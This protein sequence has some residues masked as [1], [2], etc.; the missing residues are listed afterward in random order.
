MAMVPT[1]SVERLVEHLWPWFRQTDHGVHTA[2]AEVRTCR[3][4]YTRAL[5]CP[6]F[7]D[8]DEQRRDQNEGQCEQI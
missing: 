4:V 8:E 7:C 3:V 5:P 6:V 1:C 2:R